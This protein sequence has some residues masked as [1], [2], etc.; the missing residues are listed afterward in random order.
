MKKVS[1]YLAVTIP[2][3]II[4]VI[5]VIL[6][7]TLQNS[8]KRINPMALSEKFQLVIA[9][10]NPFELSNIA[11]E[12]S[13]LE[14]LFPATEIA[15]Y[16]PLLKDIH[17]K[18][19]IENHVAW[20][21]T[22]DSIAS[23]AML[24]PV[25]E[26]TLPVKK[27]ALSILKS[28]SETIVVRKD[29]IKWSVKTVDHYYLISKD[30]FTLNLISGIL[31][32]T[33]Q[34]HKYGQIIGG[35]QIFMK[36]SVPGIK[37][38]NDATIYKFDVVQY[39]DKLYFN[40]LETD[41][42]RMNSGIALSIPSSTD[43]SLPQPFPGNNQCVI[44]NSKVNG[45]HLQT[46]ELSKGGNI[47][48]TRVVR[49]N[50]TKYNKDHFAAL[51]KPVAKGPFS[52]DNHQTG[53]KNIIV[54]DV[55]NQMYLF[56][57]KGNLI[58]KKRFRDKILGN[59]YQVDKYNNGK[60]QYLWNSADNIHL[61]DITGNEVEGFPFSVPA[62]ISGGVSIVHFKG[63]TYPNIL[64]IDNSKKLVNINLTPAIVPEWKTQTVNFTVS[65]PIQ[66]LYQNSEH[67]VVIAGDN[68]EVIMVDKTGDIRMRIKNSFTNNPNSKFYFNETNS[69]GN[70]ITTDNYGNLIYIPKFGNVK[71]TVFG[72]YSK[73]HYFFYEDY[74]FDGNKD[75]FF[76]DDKKISVFNRFKRIVFETTTLA[77]I[78][79]KP[80]IIKN[81]GETRIGVVNPQSSVLEI[82]DK[83]GKSDIIIPCSGEYLFDPGINTI[84]SVKENIIISTKL[85]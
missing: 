67:Y 76:M 55:S 27:D 81:N 53:E 65:E 41:I 16:Q 72:T 22:D 52:V 79:I 51:E 1:R 20:I 54:F 70:L 69:K 84:F 12:Y 8:G 6:F 13:D 7:F 25:S 83:N 28:D 75:F 82:Y 42:E 36:G 14:G 40:A 3:L 50:D 61:I 15:S 21:F 19:V 32:Q 31:N 80:L 45:I 24:I 5:A 23:S 17:K 56:D 44:R 30:N 60:Y 68:G 74:D 18:E 9:A 73:A 71:K 26:V 38:S 78:S 4:L 63:Y 11:G 37:A 66:Y 62:K 35:T 47:A 43:I 29:Q 59:I 49:S 34:W 39:Q 33:G 57:L 77:P 85:N 2:T 10:D 48:T 64:L 58:W 46:L